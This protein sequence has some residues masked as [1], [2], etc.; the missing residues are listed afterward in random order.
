[1]K[2]KKLDINNWSYKSLLIIL[3]FLL[4]GVVVLWKFVLPN[5]K[6]E[7]SWW[8]D[9]WNYRKAVSIS[10]TSGS[11]LTDFQVS[12]SIGTSALIASG[13]MQSDCDDIRVTDI[14]G[15][16]L[17]YWIEEN[18]PG[19]NQLTDTKI[20][21]KANSL[22][23]S[24]ATIYIYYGNTSAPSSQSGTNTF[25]FFDDFND[26]SKTNTN[27]TATGTGYTITGGNLYHSTTLE[28]T[29]NFTSY[30]INNSSGFTNG[31]IE[32]RMK[33]AS[34]GNSYGKSIIA[35]YTDDNNQ[36]IAGLEAWTGGYTHIGRRVSSTWTNI[37]QDILACSTSTWYQLKWTLNGS[38]QYLTINGVASSGVDT[39]LSSGKVGVSVDNR[40][41][42]TGA[43]WDYIF[44]H[45]YS[46]VEPTAS[47]QSE[48]AGGGPIAYWKFDEGT[49]NNAYDSSSQNNTGS[50]L[51]API[52]KNESE[53]VS[54]K[55]LAF[56]NVDDGVSINKNFVGLTDYTMSAWVN[57]KGTHQHYTGAIMSSGDWN[58]QY[59]V[60][61]ISQANDAIN[62]CAGSCSINYAFQLNKWTHVTVT[63]SG[64]QYTLYINGKNSGTYS[65]S[66]SA[67]VSSATNTTIGRE[68]Y[69]GGY[70]AFNGW[71]DEPKI[72][73]YARTADQIKLDYNSRGSSKG[74]SANLGGA[75]TDNNLSNGLVGYWK[76]DEGTMGS[77][78]TFTDSS[79]NGNTGTGVSSVAVSTGEFGNGVDIPG[80]GGSGLGSV[81]NVNDSDSLD[82]GY[83]TP[84]TISFWLNADSTACGA[85]IKKSG[86]WEI[87]RCS[88]N[89]TIRFDGYDQGSSFNLNNG[90]WYL[91]TMTRD[92]STNTTKVYING[93]QTDSWTY[94]IGTPNY[95]GGM[96]IGA[97]N[98]GSYAIDGK[99]DEVRVYNRAL[100]PSEVSQ[101]YEFAPGPIGYW[102]FNEASG[103]VANDKSGN[104]KNLTTYNSPI[105][106]QGKIGSALDFNGSTQYAR[107]TSETSFQR[108]NGQEISVSVWIYPKRLGGQYQDIVANRSSSGLNWLIYQHTTDGSI[109]FHGSAQNKSTYIPPLNQ[110]THIETTI[111]AV[112]NYKLYANGQIVQSL[113]GYT[114]GT[115][116]ITELT[117]GNFSANE[118]YLGKIDEVKI[119]NY[120]RT[121]KQIIED[122]NANHPAVS[123]NSAIAYYKFDE[124]YG[125]TTSNWGNGGSALNGT[126][127]NMA[128]PA[129][130]TSGWNNS[131]KFGKALSFDASDDYVDAGNAASLTFGSGQSFTY[132]AW[133]YS[134]NPLGRW[135]GV[136]Y[137][138]DVGQSQGH[139][140][141]NPSGQ[142]SGGTG[143]GSSW[144]THETSYLI[145]Q[146][147]WT[148]V[149][150][151]LNRN[152]NIL[153]FYANGVEVGSYSHS[154][155][156]SAPTIGLRIGDGNTGGSEHF[157]G[158][159]DEVK[160]YNYALT[161]DEIK[162]DYNQSSALQMGQTSQTI[163]GTTTSLDYCIP[164]DTSACASP[165]AEYKMDEGI[166]TTAYDT[167]GNNINAGFNSTP[168][169]TQGKI[170]KSLNFNGTTN[171]LTNTRKVITG[172]LTFGVWI[173]TTSTDST[174]TYDGNAAQNIIGDS[175]GGV[176]LGF[177]VH[178]GKVRYQH[179]T[180][181]WYS[182]LGSTS[183]N[184]GLW[185]YIS[186]THN[187]STGAIVIYVDGKQDGSGTLAY[188]GSSAY[189]IIARGYGGDYF[190][191]QLD[192]IRIYNYVRTPAQIA[193]DYNKGGPV[194]W[195]KFD[196]CQG[197]VAY[198]WSGV[199]NTGTIIIGASGTQNS[200]GTCAVGTSAAWTNGTSGKI[201]SS[202]NF[203]GV[204]DVVD[205]ADNATLN[206][207][208]FTFSAWIYSNN[209]NQE[210]VLFS[211]TN[212]SIGWHIE[213]Y[214]GK[215][216][217]QVWPGGGYTTSIKTMSNNT[218]YHIVI[219]YNNGSIIYYLNG[220]PNGTATQTFSV[221]TG[222]TKRIGLFY[223]GTYPFVGKIDDVRIYNY[224]LTS[225]QI[226]TLY[227]G[228]AVSFN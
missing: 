158:L 133:I 69:G 160:I 84:M 179:Y 54:G 32:S 167:S 132:G 62:M 75:G 33:P 57:I 131:G 14:N 100:S 129:I 151:V 216:V 96:G 186:V 168:T 128:S 226:K 169:W 46:S 156:P 150:I 192:Q 113:T 74:T 23:V 94:T 95:S 36:Y 172:G 59:W 76:M 185:H 202:L 81:I 91:V 105:W 110:W 2:S 152:S 17:P 68:T 194:G 49:G 212:A 147:R 210:Q 88:A 157:D 51:S 182:V 98:G 135:Q 39:N 214:Q 73:P 93:Q 13:K 154:Y 22:P 7:A 122:M 9:G 121:Q 24:D 120:A 60:F 15:N 198:D 174:T 219:T 89:L 83:T 176:A 72:Y 3:F 56:D 38:N 66:S 181:A 58:T 190:T 52:W 11:D 146:N 109:Q 142:L 42:A 25:E 188:N 103:T 213:V 31:I 193:Y 45:K 215:T 87:Y 170:G 77:G 71:I 175:T 171:Y 1:M 53:C 141:L 145:P 35:R 48:E 64:S 195:W 200:L 143:D 207:T 138:G 166:G 155:V 37:D 134:K 126:L 104:G 228:G 28:P 149:A 67:L 16:L 173:K 201:N 6:V 223:N 101:L 70:F 222:L 116:G 43:Y 162:Q 108:V 187:S 5:H 224:T 50:M 117:V 97:Y 204:D 208:S 199:G 102:D 80:P 221:P 115:S 34:C 79:G 12:L 137:H 165:V 178:G 217:M 112:G 26:A 140:G 55:C 191:G 127:T 189:D 106:N 99:L 161:A 92:P 184:D 107:R 144:Q 130:T 20:W 197:N 90:Q 47:L 44:T 8:N 30:T 21:I 114:F 227:N 40:E 209:F 111:D 196:E 118:Y 119:Y 85:I 218:W 86:L 29:N 203:D 82:I 163:S 65:G 18:N 205:I 153:K 159:V 139:L 41:T 211:N 61:G 19:C 225:E 148:Y 4:I 177:G 220:A 63:R 206:G 136:V 124:G 27:W 164:G 183:V 180:S 123:A 10:N 125:T 78:T